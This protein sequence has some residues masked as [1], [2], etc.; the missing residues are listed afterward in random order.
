[1]LQAQQTVENLPGHD[2]RADKMPGHWLLAQLGKRVLRPGGIAMTR[3]LLKGLAVGPKDDVAELAPGLG[4]TA[5]LILEGKPHSYAGI[6]RDADAA[7][8]TARR[9]PGGANVSVKVGRA[10]ATQLPDEA[11]SVVI[12]EAML[13][14]HPPE[15]K[16][17]IVEEAFRILRT[18]G[19]YAIHELAIVPD[20]LPNEVKKDI[21]TTL[22]SAIRVGAR[23]L[24]VEEWRNLLQDAGF[25]VESVELAPMNLLQPARLV[26]DEGLWGA[27]KFIKNVAKNSDA[28]R[29]VLSMRR[30]FHQH[31][32]HLS[33]VAIIARK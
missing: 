22:S 20:D 3:S 5:R 12:G 24:T 28:R 6:E 23:P 9:L 4:V 18:K 10:D 29:R 25:K 33:A 17:Q 8:W 2:L 27:L 14:M 11:V 1:M 19:A 21:E 16:R 31:R 15:H 7:A 13:S 30:T 32:E 26:S